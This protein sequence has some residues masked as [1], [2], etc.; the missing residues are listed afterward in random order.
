LYQ[1]KT[2]LR[3]PELVCAFSEGEEGNMSFFSGM[4]N[5]VLENREKFLRKLNI[6]PADCVA[7]SLVH[8][9]ELAEVG[10][11][12][13]GKGMGGKEAVVADGL[14][15]GEAGLYLFLLTADC[16]PAVL[17]EPEERIVALLHLSIRNSRSDLIEKTI[18]RIEGKGGRP[19]RIFVGIGPAIH[20]ESYFY[21]PVLDPEKLD[22]LSW[23]GYV[24]EKNGGAEIDLIGFNRQKFV[25]SGVLPENIEISPF[26]TAASPRFF[27]HCREC[28]TGRKEGRF[29]TIVGLRS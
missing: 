16:I 8:R 18:G 23:Q 21:K 29:A 7:L 5:E 6:F 24:R 9:D 3:F 26:D 22:I 17:Y 12:D 10:K 15:T 27:S 25:D 14:L 2:F 1:L 28:R 4:K 19:E 11:S 20:R 13:R